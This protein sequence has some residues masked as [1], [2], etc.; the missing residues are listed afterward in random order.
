VNVIICSARL[1]IIII[2]II[3]FVYSFDDIN[4]AQPTLATSATQVETIYRR[5][6]LG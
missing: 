2:M 1:H 5:V 4:N 6:K 3:M